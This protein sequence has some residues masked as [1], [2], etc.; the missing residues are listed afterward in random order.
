MFF[1]HYEEKPESR[2]FV[3][4]ICRTCPVAKQCF[5]VGVSSKEWG[6]WGGIYLENG[7]ISREF[8]NH[9]SKQEWS[10]TWQ[11]LTMEQ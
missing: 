6:V 7:E 8:N 9:R 5:A 4:S 10:L 3:D 1:D 11:S 2:E